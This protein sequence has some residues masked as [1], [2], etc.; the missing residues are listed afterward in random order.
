MTEF[1][2]RGGAPLVGEVSIPGSKNA[3]LAVLSSVM[4]AKGETVLQNMPRVRDV[5]IK[6]ALL[7]KFGVKSHWTEANT[8]HIDAT[9]LQFSEVGEDLVRPIRTSFYLVGPLLAR[10]GKVKMPAPGGCKIGARPVDFHVRGLN[11]MGAKINLD[12]G[13]YEG[14]GDHLHGEEIYLD[15]PSA[16]ATQH[17]MATATLAQGVTVIQNAATEPEVT[18]LAAFLKKMGARIEGDGTSTVTI[19]G[20]DSL[21]GCEF[22]IP[23]DR[24]QAGTYLLAG[25]ITRGDVTVRGVMPEHQTAL[26]NKLR[27]AGAWA[28]EGNDFVRV[29]VDRRLEGLRVKTMPYPGFPTDIQQPM[30]SVLALARGPSIIEETIYESRVGHISELNRMGGNLRIEGRATI[31]EGVDSLRGAIVEASDLRAGAALVLAGLAADG[32]TRVRNIHFVD[33]GYEGLEE[34]LTSLG[35]NIARVPLKESDATSSALRAE[36]H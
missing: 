15:F 25:A 16:G 13:I 8:L 17:L 32:E 10:M 23:E 18:A 35:G 11:L 34:K 7:A 9:D 14:M 22:R 24:I 20:T 19:H 3:A 30:A 12:H 4:V 27:E 6:L 36:I 2:I 5:E 21:T 26:V 31:I 1:K 33:R 29:K 28:E